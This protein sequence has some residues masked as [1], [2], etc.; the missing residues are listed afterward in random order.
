V[1][2]MEYVVTSTGTL[3]VEEML[4][5]INDLKTLF[6]IDFILDEDNI[7]L[8]RRISFLLFSKIVELEGTLKKLKVI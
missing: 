2:K 1:D 4:N 5:G 3:D 6:S 8:N 7:L